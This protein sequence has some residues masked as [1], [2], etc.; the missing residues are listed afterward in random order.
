MFVAGEDA[1]GDSIALRGAVRLDAGARVVRLADVATLTGPEAEA[2]ADLVVAELPD[3]SAVAEV[4]VRDVRAKLTDA[5]AHWG[6]LD[7]SGGR[8]I[9]RGRP[10]GDAAPPMAMTGAALE[11]VPTVAKP[12]AT[13]WL[14]AA[15]AAEATLRGELFRFVARNLGVAPDQMQMAIHGPDAAVPMSSTADRRFEIQPLGSITGAQTEVSVRAWRDGRAVDRWILRV[16]PRVRCEVAAA[17]RD[18]RRGETIAASDGTVEA[19]WLSPPAAAKAARCGAVTG[20]VAAMP[21]AAGE[22][23]LDSQLR[24]QLVVRR[25]DLVMVRCVVGGL[26]VSLRAEARADGAAGD[27]VELRK[28][29]ERETF[30][31]TISGPAEAVIDLSRRE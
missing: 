12:D 16:V 3:A 17:T 7:L 2:F 18:I 19:R 25:G 1:C 26:V 24:K 13:T 28:L 30:L 9:V 14:D 23:M 6:R 29:G 4:R 15:V 22:P 11:E 27:T 5:G 21:I 20:R 31:A 8:T 10:H